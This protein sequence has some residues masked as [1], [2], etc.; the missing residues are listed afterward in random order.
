MSPATDQASLIAGFVAAE[1]CFT[2]SG[3]GTRFT[4]QVGLGA[5][6]RGA[7]RQ[8]QEFFGVGNISESPRRQPHHDDQ[9]AF[10]VQGIHDLIGVIIPFMDEHLPPSY[11]REQYLEW[12]KRLFEFWDTK[13]RRPRVRTSVCTADG[14]ERLQ[15]AKGLCRRHYYEAYGR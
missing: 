2:A 6:D 14:C 15:R 13:A 11:K 4:F 12:R 5:V 1:G 7:C 8:L 3:A 10:A 9:T